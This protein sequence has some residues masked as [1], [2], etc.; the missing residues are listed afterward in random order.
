MQILRLALFP[1]LVCLLSGA[2]APP[3]TAALLFPGNTRTKE[4]DIPFISVSPFSLPLLLPLLSTKWRGEE[5]EQ[6][7]AL[8]ASS[9]ASINHR[10]GGGIVVV[11]IREIDRSLVGWTVA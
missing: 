5:E 4:R 9:S 8:I 3:V 6:E 11:V 1:L 10:G 7:E 2:V